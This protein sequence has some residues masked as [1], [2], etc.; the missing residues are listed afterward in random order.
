[1]PSWASPSI[2]PG[3]VR[4]MYVLYFRPLWTVSPVPH[5]TGLSSARP[6]PEPAV[7]QNALSCHPSSPGKTSHS[8]ATCGAFLGSP[9]KALL[10][11]LKKKVFVTLV[12]ERLVKADFI[13]AL[14]DRCRDPSA[15]GFCSGRDRL[16]SPPNTRKS[17]G[18]CGVSRRKVT[19]TKHQGYGWG[20]ILAKQT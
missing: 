7:P 19:K 20:W 15:A 3:L 6:R 13:Q 17:S 4:K 8:L 14:R 5:P 12:K 11:L 10:K 16:D 1:M 18:V 9:Y 2:T